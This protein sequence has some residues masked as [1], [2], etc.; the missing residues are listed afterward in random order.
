MA[1][2]GKTNNGRSRRP[3]LVYELHDLL[4]MVMATE[5]QHALAI[6]ASEYFRRFDSYA[7]CDLPAV[8]GLTTPTII[9]A[10]TLN[11]ESATRYAR[12]IFVFLELY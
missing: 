3:P 5:L 8:L 12:T 1:E 10:S 7:I 2:S 6:L 11:L 4:V 9:F